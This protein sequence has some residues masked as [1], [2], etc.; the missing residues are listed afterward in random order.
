[1]Q[2]KEDA[3]KNNAIA[4]WTYLPATDDVLDLPEFNKLKKLGSQLN[5]V[6]LDLRGV[7]GDVKREDIQIAKTNTHPNAKGH[8]LI[9]RKFYEELVKN[10]KQFIKANNKSVFLY[11]N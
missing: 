8:V 2:I 6:T 7:Y 10:K 5:Y 11:L 3:Y 9:A 4:V 1:M